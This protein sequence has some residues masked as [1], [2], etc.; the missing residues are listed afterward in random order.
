MYKRLIMLVIA[1]LLGILLTTPALGADT[2]AF[3]H[4][5][6]P[7]QPIHLLAFAV[8]DGV[9]E[10]FF[11]I[12]G[13]G[14][15]QVYVAPNAP[16]QFYVNGT[17]KACLPVV[18]EGDLPTITHYPMGGERFTWAIQD[19]YG[20]WH[21]V[22]LL[23]GEIVETPLEFDSTGRAFTRLVVER[24]KPLEAERYHIFDENGA[25]AG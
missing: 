9:Q 10:W 24:D 12:V 13:G 3:D 19:D 4:C 22:K 15:I 8:Q 21:T 11:D 14:Q 16:I 18:S 6:A 23:T 2:S 20:N 17:Y 1:T 5:L 7:Y 25:I